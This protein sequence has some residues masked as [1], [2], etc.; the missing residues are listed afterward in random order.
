VDFPRESWELMKTLADADPAAP[1]AC[2]QWTVHDLVAHL[3]AGA[4]ENA[5]L[6]EDALAGRPARA[7]RTFAE[8][9][10][11]FVAMPDEQ[12][13]QELVEQS[14]RKVA[15]L[16][17]LSARGPDATYQFTGRAFTA[18]LAQ[19]H[20]RSEAAIHRWDIAGDD[21]TSMELLAAPEL[22]R[23]AVE[24]LNTLP[25]LCEAPLSRARVAQIDKLRIVL[26]S[27]AQRDVTMDIN[28]GSAHFELAEIDQP[29]DGDAVV[30]TDP[31][32][33]LLSIWGRRAPDQRVTITAD[34]K[35]WAPVARVLWDATP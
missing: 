25:I 13:R 21:E 3:A 28:P 18:A 31:A 30:E 5:D 20:A 33:R 10:P 6:I 17:Q 26:R 22:T 27:R 14:R 24:I 29:A 15:A 8:R 7:T 19:T 11:A 9:E 12:L 35:L 16:E 1:T 32:H 2:S 23:H 4:K 34:P